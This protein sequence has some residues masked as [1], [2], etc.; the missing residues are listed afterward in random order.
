MV[1]NYAGKVN[2]G[3]RLDSL[4]GKNLLDPLFSVPLLLMVN[5]GALES[6]LLTML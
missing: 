3:L 5:P 1:G 2:V 6:V 4:A